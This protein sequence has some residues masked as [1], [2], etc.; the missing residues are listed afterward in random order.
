MRILQLGRFWNDQHGGIERH[1]AMLSQG[2]AGAGADVTNLVASL[3]DTGSDEV[4]DGYRLIRAPS[5]GIVASTA[6]SPALVWRAL[7][8]YRQKPFDIVHLHLPDP[9]SHLVSLLLPRKIKR[10]ITWHS[11]IVKQKKLLE[12][13]QPW[14][15]RL[16]HKAD[17]IV[18]ATQAHFSS[19]TQIPK[20]VDARKLRVIAYGIDHAALELTP[21][22]EPRMREIRQLAGGKLLVYALGRHV[23][24]KGFD[25]LIRAMRTVDGVLILGGDGLL[26]ESLQAQAEQLGVAGKVLFQGR[27]PEDQLAAY[28]HACDVFC[29]PSVEQSE[30]FGLV[31]AEAMACG[32]PVVNTWLHNGVNEVSRDGETGLTVPVRDPVALAAALTRLA[33][34]PELRETLGRNAVLRARSEYSMVGMT[35]AH[36]A[37]YRELLSTRR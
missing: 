15:G 32:K 17:A 20:D 12:M 16:V 13:Y 24:Y 22:M 3:D 25:V 19:S 37:L 1:V 9:L 35:S 26:R 2:L 31:Q 6:M 5:L 34:E 11:D 10:V 18:A 4:L 7:Q 36:L 33:R 30:A 29:L 23:Y 21:A 14:L 27:I 8:L 28:F